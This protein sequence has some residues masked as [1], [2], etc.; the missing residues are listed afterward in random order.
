[1][2]Y[3]KCATCG[4]RKKKIQMRISPVM[5]F[6][7]MDCQVKY[8]MKNKDRSAEKQKAERDKEFRAET[9]RRK[10]RIKS[11]GDWA[12][13][14]QAAFNRYIRLRDRDLPCISCQRHHGG[15]YHAG[16]YRTVGS[17]PELRFEESQVWKQCAPCNSHLSGNITN[18]RINLVRLIGQEKV[19]WIEGPHE[20][21]RYT[22]ED[23]K[24]IKA[25]YTKMA[26]ELE[27]SYEQAAPF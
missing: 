13:E 9:R 8:A 14:A 4:T 27:R 21:K 20:P 7:N 1:M 18:Y 25:K 5:A 19:D 15:Q 23:L 26:R 10:D 16:H 6:C 22:I 11:K 24:Q 12:K 2:S 3:R 17:C